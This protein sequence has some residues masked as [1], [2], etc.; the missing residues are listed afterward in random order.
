ME[1]F[2]TREAEVYPKQ[3]AFADMDRPQRSKK[4]L[5]KL[6]CPG[7]SDADVEV[8]SSTVADGIPRKGQKH[9][10]AYVIPHQVTRMNLI[11]IESRSF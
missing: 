8:S 1:A 6:S 7:L 4:Q 2:A 10:I 5:N 9:A 11:Q 3:I